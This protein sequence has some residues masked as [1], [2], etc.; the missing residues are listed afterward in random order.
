MNPGPTVLCVGLGVLAE[1]HVLALFLSGCRCCHL[2]PRE[3]DGT[4][5]TTSDVN[6]HHSKSL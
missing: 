6:V 4:C 1:C 3:D 2:V 5:C